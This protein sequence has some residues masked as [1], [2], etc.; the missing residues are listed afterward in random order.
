MFGIDVDDG[1]ISASEVGRSIGELVAKEL[2]VNGSQGR[3]PPNQV[4]AVE[5]GRYFL[6]DEDRR[7]ARNCQIKKREELESVVTSNVI[8]FKFFFNT[9]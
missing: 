2:S 6:T 3:R 7:T 9:F 5:A 8:C 4:E 1:S